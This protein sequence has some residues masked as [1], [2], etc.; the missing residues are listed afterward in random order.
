LTKQ[1]EQKIR[2]SLSGVGQSVYLFRLLMA[3]DAQTSPCSVTERGLGWQVLMALRR[4]SVET[5]H[6]LFTKANC[7]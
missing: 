2:F 1:R 3:T 4:R 5:L 7:K 6:N